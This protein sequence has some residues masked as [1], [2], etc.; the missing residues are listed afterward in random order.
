MLSLG[1]RETDLEPGLH[2]T[3][4]IERGADI[5]L[6]LVERGGLFPIS[7]LTCDF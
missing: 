5:H 7:W 2:Q 6:G 3:A 4:A 1:E